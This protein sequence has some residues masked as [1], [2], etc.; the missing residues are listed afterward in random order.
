MTGTDLSGADL[1]DACFAGG[2]LAH[3]D[4]SRAQLAG[5]RLADVDLAGAR[6]AGA[7]LRRA[8]ITCSAEDETACA[9][10]LGGLV[11]TDADLTEAEIGEVTARLDTDFTGATLDATE[12]RLQPGL[13]ARLADAHVASVRLAPPE[14]RLG[15]PEAF[16]GDEIRRLD[17]LG[18]GDP[19][20]LM[21]PRV[22]RGIDC[23]R[24]A[25]PLE[26]AI[27]RSADLV[28]LD[29]LLSLTR[30]RLGEPAA[31]PALAARRDRCARA[32]GRVDGA[33]LTEAYLGRLT[34]LGQRLADQVHD[35]L[36]AARRLYRAAPIAA[37][38]AVRADPLVARLV[39]AF[40]RHP[41]EATAS[42]AGAAIALILGSA[43]PDNPCAF[44]AV[45]S[46]DAA[47]KVWRDPTDP[48][49]TAWAILP[50]GIVAAGSVAPAARTC[51]MVYFRAE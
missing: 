36:T 34:G 23:R 5:A 6:L 22:P 13:F 1:T 27:C 11:L 8:V 14:G 10:S 12:L 45:V 51:A 35:E 9:R 38:A 16:S 24:T 17:R 42:A 31:D 3:S 30:E 15:Q 18:A 44:D 4:L 41:E 40:G 43:D 39:R 19:Y 49:A 25:R 2:S 32:S 7:S 21:E 50:D 47:A 48:D 20:H 33:C 29:R 28:A 26:E 46:F 37:A